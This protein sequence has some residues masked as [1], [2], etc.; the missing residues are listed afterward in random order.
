MLGSWSQPRAI[1][2][3]PIGEKLIVGEGVET[4]VAGGMRIREAAALW[5]MGSAAA[6]GNLP[7]LPG[8]TKLMILVDHDKNNVG[9][10]NARNCVKR[11]SC[12]KRN[13]V[14]LCPHQ[15][16]TD[17]NDLIGGKL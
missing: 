9:I 13:C 15:N 4:V 14:L 10:D 8:V 11:W 17:F 1:K 12:A 5:A 6:I 2:L 7:L 3:R 16:D